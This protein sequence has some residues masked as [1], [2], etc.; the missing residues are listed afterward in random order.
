MQNNQQI[1]AKG[2]KKVK[3]TKKSAKEKKEPKTTGEK[4]W[5]W[6]K[7]IFF[8]ILVVMIINGLALASFV[9]PTGSMENTVMTGDF[10]FVN[11]FKYGPT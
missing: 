7:T 4:V 6:V 8:A 1:L 11:K 3:Q 9:V 5:S 10:L 2:P